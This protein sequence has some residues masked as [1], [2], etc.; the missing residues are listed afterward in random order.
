M[1]QEQLKAQYEHAQYLAY[2]LCPDL[3]AMEMHETAADVRKAAIIIEQLTQY[4][5]YLEG[6]KA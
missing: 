5:E 3:K 2:T 6:T 4:I 1:T